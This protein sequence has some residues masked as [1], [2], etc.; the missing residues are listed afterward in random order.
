[1]GQPIFLTCEGLL[2]CVVKAPLASKFF[3]KLMDSTT[4]VLLTSSLLELP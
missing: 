4:E 2:A 3:S 1:M